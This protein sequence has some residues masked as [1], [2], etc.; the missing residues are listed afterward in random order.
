M[1]KVVLTPIGSITNGREVARVINEN[2]ERISAA[3]E[4]TLSLDG[5]EPNQ[6]LGDLDLNGY[7]LDNAVIGGEVEFE[8]L[9][10]E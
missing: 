3:I 5:T 2:F 4:N 10:S 1:P 8:G 9:D 7:T 6:L